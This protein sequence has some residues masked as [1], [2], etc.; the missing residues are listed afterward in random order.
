MIL[1]LN[2]TPITAP[3]V[4]GTTWNSNPLNGRF[5]LLVEV[6]DAPTGGGAATVA[7][8]D[9]VAVWIDNRIPTAH[10]ESIGG[11]AACGDLYLSHYKGTT[12]DILGIAWDPPIDF[13]A[14]QIRP[15]DN[16]GSYGL[17]FQKNGGSGEVRKNCRKP[18][19]RSKIDHGVGDRCGHQ[20]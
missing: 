12:A 4:Q 11:L 17:S 5:V 19:F 14:P 10:I 2:G 8:V 18:R 9:Q 7:G 15:N 16:F 6:R 20:E 1:G 3:K 13:S